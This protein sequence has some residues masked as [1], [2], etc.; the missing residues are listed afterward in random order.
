[1][2]HPLPRSLAALLL[3][4]AAPLPAAAAQQPIGTLIPASACE[5][6]ERITATGG[7]NAERVRLTPGETY[8]VIGLHRSGNLKIRVDTPGV[9]PERW[10]LKSCGA[11]AALPSPPAPAAPSTANL[12]ALSWQPS[13]CERAGDADG[14]DVVDAAAPAECKA[15][16][17]GKLDDFG[18]KIGLHGLW[19]QPRGNDY[20]GVPLAERSRDGDRGALAFH[21]GARNW[22]ALPDP[23]LDPAAAAAL[24]GWMP[25]AESDLHRHEWIKHGTCYRPDQDADRYF[26]D[27][28]MLTEAVNVALA[29]LFAAIPA[30]GRITL[31]QIRD[32]L[33]PA[34]G[35]GVDIA[36]GMSCDDR[37]GRMLFT[38]LQILL[39]GEI[40]PD[41]TAAEIGALMTE[42]HTADHACDAGIL[43]APPLFRN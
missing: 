9:R 8:P 24:P 36:V 21:G 13:F 10:V 42:A 38:E 28:M 32:A 14:D 5:A 29:P 30:D 3:I 34:F 22:A 25:G 27:A 6:Y 31:A 19:P 43:D 15:L 17:D 40:A 26:D 2:S 16:F 39:K 1:M 41:M 12:L 7:A 35:D 23:A 33:R 18:T 4:A 11:A 20:C 37:S